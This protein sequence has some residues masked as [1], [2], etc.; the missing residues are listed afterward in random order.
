[1]FITDM[2]LVQSTTYGASHQAF[3]FQSEHKAE[4]DMCF[5]WQCL[6][7]LG[8]LYVTSTVNEIA[9]LMR[10]G[11]PSRIYGGRNWMC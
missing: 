2:L 5:F 8:P 1:M 7:S 10:F 11:L 4:S 9:T 6:P 3:H